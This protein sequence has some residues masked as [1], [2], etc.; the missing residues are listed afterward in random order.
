MEPKMNEKCLK[1]ESNHGL[2][3]KTPKST[4]RMLD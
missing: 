1:I 2:Q 4:S 3:N